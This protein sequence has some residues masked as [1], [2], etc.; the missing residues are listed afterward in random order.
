MP[1][2]KKG[3]HMVLYREITYVFVLAMIAAA[4][5]LLAQTGWGT[6]LGTSLFYVLSY[7]WSFLSM[8]QW[9][10]VC[11]SI[12]L[13][14]MVCI[15]REFHLRYI[16]SILSAFLY[17]AFLDFFRDIAAEFVTL[18]G[19]LD[20]FLCFGISFLIMGAGL[21][22]FMKSGMPLVVFDI[23]VKEIVRVKKI[24]LGIV[25]T[26]FDVSLLS[27]SLGIGLIFFGKPMGLGIGT[28]FIAFFMGA[29]MQV[30]E[31]TVERMF[32]FQTGFLRPEWGIVAEDL[33][34]AVQAVEGAVV[35]GKMAVDA[36][37]DSK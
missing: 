2:Q 20:R 31:P 14:L 25:K 26:V 24:K 3:F 1:E 27:L 19:T 21:L 15:V 9:S 8:G 12:M 35:T 18:S 13:V 17:G 6:P 5:S 32:S 4:V 37:D 23:I 11:Q 36:H 29:Y 33:Q 28:C 22:V 30:L 16:Y 7:K 10:W 34:P